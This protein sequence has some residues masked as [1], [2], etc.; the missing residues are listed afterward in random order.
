M[1]SIATSIFFKYSQAQEVILFDLNMKNFDINAKGANTS[2]KK[3][4]KT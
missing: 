2:S 1:N 4:A 3:D